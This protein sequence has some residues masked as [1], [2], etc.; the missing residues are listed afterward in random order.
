[1]FTMKQYIKLIKSHE[2]EDYE[3]RDTNTIISI[4]EKHNIDI[5]FEEAYDLW[6]YY[7]RTDFDADWL[8]IG[9]DTDE[10]YIFNI[11]IETA[12]EMY[13]RKQDYYY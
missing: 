10:D 8:G 3:I 7:S 12:K 4:C 9:K 13:Q 2:Y 5:T 1:M 6:R 11:I